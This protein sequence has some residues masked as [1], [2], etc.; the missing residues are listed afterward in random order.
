M[1]TL[2]ILLSELIRI[3]SAD[4]MKS[5]VFLKG[6]VNARKLVSILALTPELISRRFALSRALLGMRP[7][8]R[9]RLVRWRK[10]MFVRG[11]CSRKINDATRLAFNHHSLGFA[12]QRLSL[13][14]PSL[15]V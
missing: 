2:L 9:E 4:D 11:T 15:N 8:L 12:S 3:K 6:I 7:Y 13:E 14:N 5:S 10:N 1:K